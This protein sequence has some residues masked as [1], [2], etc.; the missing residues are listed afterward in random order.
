[1]A[2]GV[3]VDWGE[4]MLT[5]NNGDRYKFTLEGLEV[6]GVGVTQVQA[7][8]EVYNLGQISDFAGIYVAAKANMSVVRGPGVRVMENAHGVVIYL[9]SKQEGVK[10]TLAAEGI[11]INLLQ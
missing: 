11:R 1:M 2:L 3:G 7:Q 4:G 9:S 5:L 8:G 6:G 10:L